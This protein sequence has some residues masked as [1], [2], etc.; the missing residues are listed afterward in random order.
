VDAGGGEAA[1]SRRRAH[2]GGAL[3]VATPDDAAAHAATPGRAEGARGCAEGQG[4][5]RRVSRDA[6]WAA[7]QKVGD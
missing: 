4:R 5:T 1:C 2:E 7:L 3:N 6:E